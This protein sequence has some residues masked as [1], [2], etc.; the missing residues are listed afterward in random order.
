VKLRSARFLGTQLGQDER[1]RETRKLLEEVGKT[2]D[3]R[4]VVRLA[5]GQLWRETAE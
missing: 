4:G 2:H 3:L 5:P 1:L